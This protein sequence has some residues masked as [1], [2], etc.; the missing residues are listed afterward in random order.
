M[1][2]EICLGGKYQAEFLLAKGDLVVDL[3][4]L[5]MQKRSPKAI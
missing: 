5:I 3:C 1:I 2:D 4:D